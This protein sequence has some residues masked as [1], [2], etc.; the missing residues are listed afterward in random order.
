MSGLQTAVLAARLRFTED[1]LILMED[2]LEFLKQHY[3]SKPDFTT[4]HD[5]NAEH[6]IHVMP[7]S[8]EHEKQVH[9]VVDYWAS[10]DPT[11]NKQYTGR[12]LHWYHQKGIRQEDHP[13]VREALEGFHAF[14]VSACGP[15]VEFTRATIVATACGKAFGF[16]HPVCVGHAAPP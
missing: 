7:G 15:P 14:T 13:R 9:K 8:A 1:A 11:P 6:P 12:V 2:R 3:A 5:P 10:H 4:H 16:H